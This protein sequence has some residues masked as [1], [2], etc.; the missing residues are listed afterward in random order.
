VR[1]EPGP[2]CRL[3]GRLPVGPADDRHPRHQVLAE[4]EE[5][6]VGARLDDRHD[7]EAAPLRVLG[8]QQAAYVVDGDVDLVVVHAGSHRR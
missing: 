1:R 8:S 7:R 5:G 3:G 2:L 4:P 6:V